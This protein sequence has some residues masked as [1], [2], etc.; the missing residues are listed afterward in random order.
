M[1]WKSISH[2]FGNNGPKR[3]S[4]NC[5]QTYEESSDE[6]YSEASTDEGLECP[7][8]W[9]L[10][11]ECFHALCGHTLCKNCLLWSKQWANSSFPIQYQIP[12]FISCPWCNMLTLRL[13]YKGNLK[14]PSK[15]F[16]LLWMVECRNGERGKSPSALREDVQLVWTP[17]CTH[18]SRNSPSGSINQRTRL[19]RVE[20]NVSDESQA[21]SSRPLERRRLS[22]QA[23]LD[24][25]LFLLLRVNLVHF[26]LLFLYFPTSASRLLL[27]VSAHHCSLWGSVVPSVIFRISS[28]RLACKGDHY[29]TF[30]NGSELSCIRLVVSAVLEKCVQI[31][32]LAE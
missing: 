4:L 31:L 10:I 23:S 14:C 7:I 12:F 32:M 17:R 20:S 22:L 18:V 19:A 8:C 6:T 1:M 15:N 13:L 28:F 5:S 11:V 2:A 9:E 29:I 25:L 26:V 24:F 21:S 16:F 27:R 30:D 3:E